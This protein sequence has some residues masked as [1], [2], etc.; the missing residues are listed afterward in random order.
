MNKKKIIT[1]FILLVYMVL[2]TFFLASCGGDPAL[3]SFAKAISETKPATVEGAMDMYTEFGPLNVTYTAS[4]ASDGS[5]VLKYEYDKFNDIATGGSAD[6]TSTIKGEVTYKDGAYSDT[7]LAA[8]IPAEATAV[9]VDLD[10][11]KMTY[12]VSEDGNVLAA[13]VKAADTKDVLGVEYAADVNLVLTKAEDKIVSLSLTYT[14][15]EGKVE[16]VCNYK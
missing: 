3:E 14:L 15:T 11:D 5:F 12:T 7:A 1:A 6:V 13:T 16:V 9:K 4:I 2:G 10:E 8:K